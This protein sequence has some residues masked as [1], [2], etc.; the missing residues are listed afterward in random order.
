MTWKK[1][2]VDGYK[3]TLKKQHKAY[4]LIICVIFFGIYEIKKKEEKLHL[5]TAQRNG[6]KFSCILSSLKSL[7][8]PGCA[9]SLP[10]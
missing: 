8:T 6:N 9:T 2:I 1:N 3:I 4:P 10:T 5:I 7:L